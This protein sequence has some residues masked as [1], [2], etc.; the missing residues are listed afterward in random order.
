MKKTIT[1]EIF[2]DSAQALFSK[3]GLPYVKAT[4]VEKDEEGN[5]T[6]F[7]NACFFPDEA[8][9][10]KLRNYL[11]RGR[12]VTVTGEYS[13]REYEGRDGNMKTAYDILVHD[14]KLGGIVEYDGEM[15]KTDF[16]FIKKD[17]EKAA[18]KDLL[19]IT[20]KPA[21]KEAPKTKMTEPEDEDD[22]NMDDLDL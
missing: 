20:K 22:F 17:D 15:K 7:V 18:N 9:V 13:E 10:Q 12:E 2:G 21:K 16:S 4:V 3:K 11:C 6:K 19:K 1:G 8:D 14:V 5:I